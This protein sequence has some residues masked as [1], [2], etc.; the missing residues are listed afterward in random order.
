[1]VQCFR[2]YRVAERFWSSVHVKISPRHAYYIWLEDTIASQWNQCR[3]TK[4]LTDCNSGV[5][6][7]KFSQLLRIDGTVVSCCTPRC[8]IL[9]TKKF[10]TCVFFFTFCLVV[11][12]DKI[13]LISFLYSCLQFSCI[14]LDAGQRRSAPVEEE[15]NFNPKPD[16]LLHNSGL[17]IPFAYLLQFYSSRR[18]FALA[19]TEAPMVEKTNSSKKLH[20]DFI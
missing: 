6:T 15:T 14:T 11:F 3:K 4:K 2:R 9:S 19:A 18:K 12:T 20:P 8:D 16:P 13:Q 5:Q 10:D 17:L 7:I 1:M